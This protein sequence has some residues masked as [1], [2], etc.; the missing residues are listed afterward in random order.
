MVPDS[1]YG[2]SLPL[3]KNCVQTCRRPIML[4]PVRLLDSLPDGNGSCQLLSLG[5]G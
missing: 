5:F 2:T 1:I 4:S 3:I